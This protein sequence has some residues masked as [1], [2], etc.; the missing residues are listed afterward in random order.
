MLVTAEERSVAELGRHVAGVGEDVDDALLYEVHLDA[1]R[2]FSD[3]VVARLEHLVLQF[4]H[5]L[6]HEVR[7]GVCKKRNGSDQR[8]AVVIDDL[9]WTTKLIHYHNQRLNST[10][11]SLVIT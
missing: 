7:V 5:H 2:T 3:D 4:G 8:S 6:S 9:L 10:V 11:K 1:G